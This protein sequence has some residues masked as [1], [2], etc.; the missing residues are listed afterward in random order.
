MNL[1]IETDQ[2]LYPLIGYISS[3]TFFTIL[4]LI[5]TLVMAFLI[6]ASGALGGVVVK[7]LIDKFKKKK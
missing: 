2:L 7:K 1:R 3:I 6:G 4:D 5:G